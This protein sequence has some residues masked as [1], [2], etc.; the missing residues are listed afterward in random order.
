MSAIDAKAFDEARTALE[1]VL[2]GRLTQRVATLMARIESEQNGNKGRVREWLARAVNAEHDPVWTADGVVS[3]QWAPISPVTGQLDAFV[4]RVPVELVGASDTELMARKVEEL[5]ALGAPVADAVVVEPAMPVVATVAKVAE[6]PA[7]RPESRP[8]PARS[9]TVTEA[10][11]VTEATSSP[12]QAAVTTAKPQPVAQTGSQPGPQT[13]AKAAPKAVPVAP[14]KPAAPIKSAQVAEAAKPT[15]SAPAKKS[16]DP[17][18]K[19]RIF[20]APHAPD[21]PGPDADQD[22]PNKGVRPPYR[23]V[24]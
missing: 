13:V 17:A 10:I 9:A 15:A 23:A 2:D 20:S 6:N 5:I 21:D 19:E 12:V 18:A 3:E 16:G 22:V 24:P 1:P 11:V 14:S 8:A 4:W 7:A